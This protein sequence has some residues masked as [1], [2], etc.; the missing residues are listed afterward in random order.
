MLLLLVLYRHSDAQSPDA[1]LISDQLNSESFG[2]TGAP[3]P[4]EPG[5]LLVSVM[6]SGAISLVGEDL[7]LMI[8]DQLAKDPELEIASLGC[9]CFGHV[10]NS[11]D[12]Y[13]T[14]A[15]GSAY[16][17]NCNVNVQNHK[18]DCCGRVK[19]ALA[20]LTA[21]QKQS[22]ATCLCNS[23]RPAGPVFAY[24]AIG[25][26]P[27]EQCD[28]KIA[29]IV[30]PPAYSVTTC[31][32]PAGWLANPTNVDGGV[33]SDGKCKKGVCGPWNATAIPPPPNG[34]AIGTWGFTWS[35]GIYVWGTTANGGA[36][37]CVTVNYP[38]G[39]CSVT[40]P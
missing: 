33:T 5:M 7:P 24:Y 36:P 28:N 3:Q 30:R 22:I 19:N 31:T 14:G 16:N 15:L 35:N 37:N 29:T 20:V 8:I 40:W 34:T 4:I 13:A 23:G 12:C 11:P 18:S 2:D 17:T 1:G 32:C 27:Y 25:T 39:P 26:K 21:A 9:H 10:S 38:A 6:P